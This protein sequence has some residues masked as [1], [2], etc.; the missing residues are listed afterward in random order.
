MTSRVATTCFDPSSSPPKRRPR[1][2]EPYSRSVT[3]L[4]HP[5]PRD[6]PE[7]FARA[8]VG[9]VNERFPKW[10]PRG[11][12]EL[13]ETRL[14]EMPHDHAVEV[15]FRVQR[16]P[17]TTYGCR[18]E[19]VCREATDDLMA[20]EDMGYEATNVLDPAVTVMLANLE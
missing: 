1:R 6:E 7:A 19:H 20:A 14:L 9:A 2:V 18:W 5:S 3:R 13:K 17:D 10:F 4:P 16:Q 11:D 15:I 8:F 12:V